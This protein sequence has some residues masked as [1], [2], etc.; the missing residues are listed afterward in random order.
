[1]ISLIGYIGMALTLISFTI[2]DMRKLRIV[3]LIGSLF[4]I[5]YGIGIGAGP[6]IGVNTIVVGIHSVWLYKNK[7]NKSK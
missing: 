6:T 7:K 3:N 5:V 1:M 2:D 4:W